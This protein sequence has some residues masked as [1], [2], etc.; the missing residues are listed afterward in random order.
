MRNPQGTGTRS[1]AHELS[2][3]SGR[4]PSL[5]VQDL[6]SPKRHGVVCIGIDITCA[7]VSRYVLI[8]KDGFTRCRLWRSN[9]KGGTRCWDETRT[10]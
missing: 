3:R 8:F 10:A 6:V 1:P 5:P 4:A 2:L 7:A 9:H